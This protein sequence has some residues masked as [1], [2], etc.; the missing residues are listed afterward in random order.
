MKRIIG[1][2]VLV[3]FLTS[4]SSLTEFLKIPVLIS[5]FSEHKNASKN[6]SFFDFVY[7]HYINESVDDTQDKDY[8]KDSR[9]PF[10]SDEISHYHFAPFVL[11]Q[12]DVEL[13]L[14]P[15]NFF[16]RN[17][18]YTPLISFT[19]NIWQPPRVNLSI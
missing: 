7:Q 15:G 3:S 5:H 16:F 1:I 6:L 19:P 2:I 13:S 12:T 18:K 9:L 4:A 17:Q 8:D 11:T 10:K 14:I